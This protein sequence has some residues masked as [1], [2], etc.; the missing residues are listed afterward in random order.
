MVNEPVLAQAIYDFRFIAS[1][2]SRQQQVSPFLLLFLTIPA[3]TIHAPNRIKAIGQKGIPCIHASEIN[4][5]FCKSQITPMT[6]IIVPQNLADFFPVR[7]IE[8]LR[9]LPFPWFVELFSCIPLLLRISGMFRCFVI[10]F[11]TAQSGHHFGHLCHVRV[12]FRKA[13]LVC[14][15]IRAELP[16]FTHDF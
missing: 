12:F 16:H 4:P 13:L 5:V 10:R 15:H 1:C 3:A 9:A 6:I 8:P 14:A 11:L 2:S 7:Q